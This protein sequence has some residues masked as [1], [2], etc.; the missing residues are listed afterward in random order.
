MDGDISQ[1]V[2]ITTLFFYIITLTNNTSYSVFP[3][4]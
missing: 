3:E 4:F 2:N 1:N